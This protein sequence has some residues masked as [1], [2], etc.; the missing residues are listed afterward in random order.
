MRVH[1]AFAMDMAK[2]I[3]KQPEQFASFFRGE[4]MTAENSSEVFLS[5]FHH[6]VN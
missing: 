5:V 1:E 4:W 6:Q 3:E 2:G